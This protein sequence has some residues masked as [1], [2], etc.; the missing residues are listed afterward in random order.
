MEYRN[1][2]PDEIDQMKRLWKVC[3]GDE[4]AYIDFYYAHGYEAANTF[5]AAE[6]ERVV[7][8]MTL[9]PVTMRTEQGSFRG[10]YV[11]A[12]ATDPQHRGRGLMTALE[13]YAARTVQAQGDAFLTLVPASMPLFG[14]YRKIG[15]HLFSSLS[16]QKLESGKR[17]GKALPTTV[18]PL[19]DAAFLEQRSRFLSQFSPSVSFAPT[20]QDYFLQELRFNGCQALALEN[21]RGSGYVLCYTEQGEAFIRELS[22][23]PAC[24]AGALSALRDYLSVKTMNLKAQADWQ[25]NL[26]TRPYSMVKWLDRKPVGP[27][28]DS[29][30]NLMLD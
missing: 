29:Y 1:P 6:Q 14:M 12:V 11:Y 7:S 16:Y 2:R 25:D 9:L 26:L 24:F 10:R 23:S 30:M 21:A 13:A 4:D 18:K 20:V 22:V 19:D 5:V 15:Y 17:A 27:S 8:M 28:A 3:F